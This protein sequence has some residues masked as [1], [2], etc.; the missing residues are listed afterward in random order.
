MVVSLFQDGVS[1]GVMKKEEFKF[2]NFLRV[3]WRSYMLMMML[4]L[5]EKIGG[6]SEGKR[7]VGGLLLL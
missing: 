5:R 1:V 7:F 4:V 6:F 3:S 2:M